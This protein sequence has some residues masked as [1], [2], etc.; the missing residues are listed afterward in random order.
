MKWQSNSALLLP[1]VTVRADMN[2]P[3]HNPGG[4]AGGY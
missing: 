2:R 3:K 1:H 4:A